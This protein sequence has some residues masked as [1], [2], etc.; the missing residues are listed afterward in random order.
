MTHEDLV[1]RQIQCVIRL[2]A[3]LPTCLWVETWIVELP[4]AAAELVWI[5]PMSPQT[6]AVVANRDLL[7]ILRGKFGIVVTARI[8]CCRFI[9]GFR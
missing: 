9:R 7:R 2:G 1:V 6:P 3:V 5:R 4:H 8:H